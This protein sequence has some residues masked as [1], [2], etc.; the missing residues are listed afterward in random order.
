MYT[1]AG[2]H[3]TRSS[4]VPRANLLLQLVISSP[5]HAR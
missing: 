5:R 3:Y 4:A 2:I 1:S